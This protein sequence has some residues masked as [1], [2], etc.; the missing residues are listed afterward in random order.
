MNFLRTN[1]VNLNFTRNP[2]TLSLFDHLIEIPMHLW[3]CDDTNC[4]VMARKICVLPYTEAYQTVDTPKHFN[5]LNVLFENVERI[6][7]VSVAGA[8]AFCKSNEAVCKIQDHNPYVVTL[9][10]GLKLA[11][12]LGLDSI[13]TIQKEKRLTLTR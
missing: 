5:N 12:K 10:K 4:A 1:Q 8:I 6:S 13:A 2:P 9:K 7:S 3:W 11:K